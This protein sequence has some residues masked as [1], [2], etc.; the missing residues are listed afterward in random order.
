LSPMEH[1]DY[2]GTLLIPAVG[3]MLNQTGLGL[4]GWGKKIPVNPYNLQTV[5]RDEMLVA[6]S[7][8]LSNLFIAFAAILIHRLL[9]S[10]DPGMSKMVML[11]AFTAVFLGLFNSLPFPWLDGWTIV[12]VLFNLP[13]ELM[14]QYSLYWYIGLLIILNLTPLQSYLFWLATVITRLMEAVL[15]V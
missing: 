9:P 12:R 14:E 4:V 10:A 1:I 13:M 15:G 6:L 11:F 8:P 3:L 7:G 5:P 2:W